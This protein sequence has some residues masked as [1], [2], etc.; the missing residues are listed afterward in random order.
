MTCGRNNMRLS[1]QTIYNLE[2]LVEFVFG[3]GGSHGVEAQLKLQ[4]RL[5]YVWGEDNRRLYPDHYKPYL[6]I[7]RGSQRTKGGE[8]DVCI[9]TNPRYIYG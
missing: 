5:G 9:K 1:L 6:D 2:K 3:R 7:V 4:V 8:I